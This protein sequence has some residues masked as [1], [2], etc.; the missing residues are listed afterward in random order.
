MKIGVV[1]AS[2]SA[3]SWDE[4]AT[5]AR[6]LVGALACLSDVTILCAT[7]EH[8]AKATDGAATRLTFPSAPLDPARARAVRLLVEGPDLDNWSPPCAC[9]Q[10]ARRMVARS[11]PAEV[12]NELVR[13]HGGE[14]PAL[15]EHVA[16]SSYDALVCIDYRTHATLHSLRIAPD[17]T[18]TVLVPLARN[19]PGLGLPIYD[20]VFE[21]V[22][23]IVT[24]SNHELGLVKDRAGREK[25]ATTAVG[26]VVRV[27]ELA[28]R[29]APLVFD[30]VP[31]VVV[32]RDWA[33]TADRGALVQQARR[34]NHDL[35][36]RGVVRLVGPGWQD[37]PDDVRAPHA[38]SRFDTW[39]WTV[40]ARAFWD[41]EPD[42]ILGVDAIEALQYGTPII[43]PST[44]GATLDHAADGDAG[45][46]YRSYD[47]LLAAVDLLVSDSA[48]R[49]GLG[50][51]G[52]DYATARY[53][54]TDRFIDEVR[55]VIE[56]ATS[57]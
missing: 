57:R 49:N 12:Q 32:A 20:E 24:A 51:Q 52:R 34:L 56:L 28:R 27:H 37:L 1:T 48:T 53:G 5:F 39:R 21:S 43:V 29:N 42:R 35:A 3:T 8:A 11:A 36:G 44:G 31:T 30:D 13:L 54:D 9:V 10:G 45:L 50:E 26:S 19:E 46:W 17:A 7:G 25:P 41:P 16:T 23:A 4:S 55:D 22:D 14:S 38:E 33:A 40:R 2:A 47:E 18:A 6:R 15:V